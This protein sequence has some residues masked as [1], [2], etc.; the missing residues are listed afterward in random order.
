MHTAANTQRV[1]AAGASTAVAVVLPEA[2]V[3]LLLLAHLECDEWIH[4]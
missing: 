4:R 3:L 2:L 1:A